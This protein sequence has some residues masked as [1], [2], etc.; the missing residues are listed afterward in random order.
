MSDPLPATADWT[1]IYD[2]D[3][4]LC[5][6]LLALLL[7]A[8]TRRRL[9][10]LAL[11]TPEADRLLS[12]LTPAERDASW[13]LVDP[14][15]HRESAGAAS[16][17]LMRLLPGGAA[18]AALLA[19][20]PPATERAYRLVADNRSALGPLIPGAV[21]DR[22]SALVA[23]RTAAADGPAADGPAADEPAADEPAADGPGSGPNHHAS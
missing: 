23:R 19:I 4:G 18:P 3:C 13:H 1:V 10:P 5:K 12:D 15:G 11:H 8:D 14:D 7:R 16:P 6:T 2:G 9:R 22:A 17:P 21:K 20:A